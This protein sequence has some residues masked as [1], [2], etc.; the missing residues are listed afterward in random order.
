MSNDFFILN[1]HKLLK[2]GLVLV[3]HM[4]ERFIKLNIQKNLTG[5]NTPNPLVRTH[6]KYKPT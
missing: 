1:Q 3:K 6:I 4:Q 5:T 2:E